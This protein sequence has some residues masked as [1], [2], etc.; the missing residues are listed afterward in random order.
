M[1]SELFRVWHL[2]SDLS[3]QIAHNHK[4]SKT[5]QQQTGMLKTEAAN[6]GSGFALRR[7]NTDISK[8]F[9]D[10]ELERMNAQIII[11]NQTLLHENKQ[12]SLLL[13]EYESTLDTIMS[14]FRNH[15]LAAQQHELTLTRHYE[16]LILA[17]ENQDF[18]TELSST[19]NMTHTLQRLSYY[20]RCLF[21]SMAG[22]KTDEDEDDSNPDPDYDP[23]GSGSF[24]DPSELSTLISALEGKVGPEQDGSLTI[25]AGRDDWSLERESEIERLEKENEQLRKM[26]GIDQGTMAEAGVDIQADLER[27]NR[28]RNPELFDKSRSGHSHS[29]SGEWGSG[30]SSPSFWDNIGKGNVG[31]GGGMSN[32]PTYS[33]VA[34]SGIG[35]APLQRAADLPGTTGSRLGTGPR[36]GGI[37]Q[38][39]AWSP[40]PGR[41]SGTVMFPPS[42]GNPNA[43]FWN[44]PSPAPPSIGDRPWPSQGGPGLDLNR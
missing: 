30:S 39:G 3:E 41:S 28:S 11:E 9:F 15:A 40:A 43:N 27:M 19:I 5:L 16:T 21:R 13:K 37:P 20:L 6:S 8:E 32:P 18:S 4:M 35:G 44:T 38:R 33:Q 2:I 23:S 12:L 1:E 22:E 10:S 29:G 31:I 17:R 34:Q 42:M 14:K 26:L 7:Y 25:L 36:R 24:I